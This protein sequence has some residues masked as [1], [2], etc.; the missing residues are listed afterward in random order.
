MSVTG[1]SSEG[2]GGELLH[3]VTSFHL[4]LSRDILEDNVKIALLNARTPGVAATHV[5]LE[6]DRKELFARIDPTLAEQLS[7][8][9][10]QGKVVIST[11]PTRPTYAD[12][13]LYSNT[14]GDAYVAV[15]N[16]DILFP[17]ETVA[18]IVASGLKPAQACFALTRWNVTPNGM[19]IQGMTPSPPWP[20]RHVSDMR[21]HEQNF[22]SY[23]AYVF[24]A[25]IAVPPD[26][27]GVLIGS[28]GCDT[29][30]AAILKASGYV[31]SN[32]A[33]PLR[34]AHFDVKPRSYRSPSAIA[35]LDR[36]VDALVAALRRPEARLAESVR[37]LFGASDKLA[38][39]RLWF[40]HGDVGRFGRALQRAI[41]ATAWSEHASPIPLRLRR[42]KVDRSD[43]ERETFDVDTIVADC[44]AARTFI[45]WEVTGFRQDEHVLDVLMSSPY[46]DRAFPIWQY[47]WQS[48]HAPEHMTRDD[49]RLYDEVMAVFRATLM[50]MREP[51]VHVDPLTHSEAMA[52][53][54]RL[55]DLLRQDLE[56]ETL[57]S[58]R[59]HEASPRILM[60]DP[61]ALG[62]MGHYLPYDLQLQN[63]AAAR[64]IDVSFLMNKKMDLALV[65]SGMKVHLLLD[66][67]SWEIAGRG[68]EHPRSDSFV[69]ALEAAIA[70][71]KRAAPDQVLMIYMY[72]GSFEHARLVQEVMAKYDDVSAVIHLF[73]LSVDAYKSD[74]YL[75][76]W[77]HFAKTV[78]SDPRI[79]LT[80]AT[81]NIQAVLQR[82]TGIFFD[83][84][85]HPSTTFDDKAD[86]SR[87][88][89]KQLEAGQTP[90]VLF[91]G[92]MREEK[93]FLSTVEA[94]RSLT[95][96]G[97][98]KFQCIVAG[99]ARSDTPSALLAGLQSIRN[100]L[101]KIEERGLDE[102]EF[103]DFLASG[104]IVV[105]PYKAAAFAERPSGILIDA[106]TLGRPL[107]VVEGTWLAEVVR[108]YGW[109]EV[110]SDDGG[111]AVA[112]A[113]RKMR[114]RYQQ[115]IDAIRTSREGYI[116]QHSWDRLIKSIVK[117]VRAGPRRQPIGIRIVSY[118]RSDH[119]SV[120]ETGVVARLLRDRKGRRNTLLDVGAHIGTSA[121]FFHEL[122]WTIHCF[123]PD[124]AN[125]EQLVA[126]LGDATS[127]VIDTRAVSDKPA[128]GVAFY[129]SPESTG[130]S[131]L[132]AFRE[133]HQEANVVDVT[134][135]ADYVHAWGI[136]KVDFLK[137]DAEGFDFSVLKGVPWDRIKPDVIECEYEDAKTVPLGHNWEDIAKFLQG[138]GYSV[139]ISEW[140]PIVRYGIA[141]DWR[142]VTPYPGRSIPSE[143]WGNILAFRV[144]P[145]YAA[146]KE[147]FDA[148]LLK[149]AA[150]PKPAVVEIQPLVSSEPALV[151]PDDLR[152][153]KNAYEGKR[154]FVMGNG[155]S[156]NKMDLS[157]LE[158][159]IVFGC[160]SI[161]LLFD[162]VKWRPT[163]YTCVDS[164]VLPDRSVEIA[165]M[166]RD[167]P[168]M[169]A[170]FPTELQD[171][172]SKVLTP[173]R[174]ILPALP[175]VAYFRER[176]NSKD[177]PPF[178]MFSIDINEHVIQPFTVAITMLQ[179]AMYMGFSEIYLIGCDT[180]YTIPPDVKKEGMTERGEI[181]LGLTSTQDNDP[182]H[183]DPRYFGKDRKWHDPQVDKMI[184]H[185][186]YA[187]QVSELRGKTTIF[188]ATVG[189]NL[190]V[191]SRVDFNSLFP[192]K[193]GE[194]TAP[195]PGKVGNGRDSYIR[196]V[197]I[198]VRSPSPLA[199]VAAAVPVPTTTTSAA[200][201]LTLFPIR[202]GPAWGSESFIGR[203]PAAAI[204]PPQVTIQPVL[205]EPVIQPAVAGAE[206]ARM[207]SAAE[208][209][210]GAPATKKVAASSRLPVGRWAVTQILSRRMAPVTLAM[211]AC[212]VAGAGFL[213]AMPPQ[214]D[215]RPM[216][217]AGA[218]VALLG[219]CG[220]YF[221]YRVVKL[222]QRLSAENA[223]LQQRLLETSGA[224]E[225]LKSDTHNEHARQSSSVT[226]IAGRIERSLAASVQD[227]GSRIISLDSAVKD[228]LR[229]MADAQKRAEDSIDALNARIASID[230]GLAGAKA[231]AGAETQR[232]SAL[233][234]HL[235]RVDAASRRTAVSAEAAANDLQASI[236][237]LRLRFEEAERRQQAADAAFADSMAVIEGLT[238]AGVENQV[239]TAGDLELLAE[240]AARIEAELVRVRNKS[241]SD[242]QH[243]SLV[244]ERIAYLDDVSKG[245]ANAAEVASE[246]LGQ[247]VLET[248]NMV[249]AAEQRL[250]SL[251]SL[252]NAGLQGLGQQVLTSEARLTDRVTDIDRAVAAVV[253]S[254]D[255]LGRDFTRKIEAADTRGVARIATLESQV[256][257]IAAKADNDVALLS[258][259]LS[260]L[261]GHAQGLVAEVSRGLADVDNR[262]VDA[263]DRIASLESESL[264]IKRSL[265]VAS[266][267]G[268]E[269]ISALQEKVNTVLSGMTDQ[270]SWV[271]GELEKLSTWMSEFGEKV[272]QDLSN[273]DGRLGTFE[274]SISR[275][276][277][278]VQTADSLV[279]QTASR[280][281]ILSNNL[282]AE[283]KAAL[284]LKADE[285]ESRLIKL[286]LAGLQAAASQVSLEQ[287]LMVTKIEAIR[288]EISAI[289]SKHEVAE[290]AL[291]GELASLAAGAAGWGSKIE[292]LEAQQNSFKHALEGAEAAGDAKLSALLREYAELA[293]AL[294]AVRADAA[295]Q[296]VRFEE[297]VTVVG[298]S[299]V[300]ELAQAESRLRE[301]LATKAD[302]S[303][304]A[305]LTLDVSALKV[306]TDLKADSADVA[307]IK[308]ELAELS[309]LSSEAAV[310]RSRLDA[311]ISASMFDV[312][313]IDTKIEKVVV[314]KLA[315][316]TTEAA[317]LAQTL[318]LI[319]GKQIAL[320]DALDA[321]KA[322]GVREV[323]TIERSINSL[324]KSSATE[325]AQ[326]EARL[327][328]LIVP[329]AEASDVLSIMQEVSALKAWTEQAVV[330]ATQLAEMAQIDAASALVDNASSYR[331]SNR[332]LEVEHMQLLEAQWAPSLSVTTSRQGL[333]YMAARAAEVE[334]EL[335]GRFGAAIE[336]LLVRLLVARATKGAS[337]AI[338]EIGVLFG[339]GAAIVFDAVK[340][341]FSNVHFTLL[342]PLDSS[343]EGR[344]PDALTDH[345]VNE[346]VVRR[347][348]ARAGMG[349]SQFRLLKRSSSDPN[350]LKDAA[351]R[352]YDVLIIDGDRSYQAVKSDFESFSPL[353]RIGGHVVFTGYG[354]DSSPNVRAF[355]DAEV[356]AAETVTSVGVAWD[357]A[358]FRV[359]TVPS[360]P[361]V[362]RATTRNKSSKS[363]KS[364]ASGSKRSRT[365]RKR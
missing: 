222:A 303:D 29:T 183:F 78:A 160:N 62:G 198:P 272:S 348:L 140:H 357:T 275:L 312:A 317:R 227:V 233:A 135:I 137:I 345:P 252:V 98:P 308:S 194:K 63:A 68:I 174:E 5:L 315:E 129:K 362:R 337:I 133:T 37:A 104:D 185:Y 148:C 152:R 347:N 356:L 281:E 240:R 168:T 56:D 278:R 132:H 177:Y 38:R 277:D 273:V 32:P 309:D 122:G 340:D 189:G 131:A 72:C 290:R 248:R 51:G 318:D 107:I 221:A 231:V 43:I 70:S 325:L 320:Q 225:R 108:H 163:F 262:M 276:E 239:R 111:M 363:S 80:V 268:A 18:R 249:E 156:L 141:H 179:I 125:R 207:S 154:C 30:L 305:D 336:D 52:M 326:I 255:A 25:P 67:H 130:I 14:V 296:G 266:V 241:N 54:D 321:A 180:S 284:S 256:S 182:N 195:A 269:Q 264:T 213:L 324:G 212:L 149:R 4:K 53:A 331:V 157:K 46:R 358:V 109:G 158:G 238:E 243:M 66:S 144:D 151:R 171:H 6:G 234:E 247:Q 113:V 304:L 230:A 208:P 102:R 211:V 82:K 20:E 354:S 170:F 192:A 301:L 316:V 118:E 349:P 285:A 42:V 73:W 161:F 19:F 260:D 34:I 2:T 359:V 202:S 84:A 244:L 216:L 162:R 334:R 85:P 267:D 289:D 365:T 178:S 293:L 103:I 206:P 164:R 224:L 235:A 166:L 333:A 86:V 344:V 310:D 136:E 99:R 291:G 292:L 254:V 360:R 253:G 145:G 55:S 343:P 341:R 279:A 95:T 69:A 60:I 200:A 361:T 282:A 307:F 263:F 327:E 23:D 93:G 96:T 342:D 251:T 11:L 21:R 335:D 193:A 204:V 49:F 181:G 79:R 226:S 329:K 59:A 3:V 323:E 17:I 188:N 228:D 112:T 64:S 44:E 12:I 236:V 1:S 203:E 201:G 176:W 299:A 270:R 28:L 246:A 127:V 92:A 351:D 57:T 274:Q 88:P 319:Q 22:F 339:V 355:V 175:N 9:V 350:A 364:N 218:G 110:V 196:P 61:D 245:A 26:T 100:P 58:V 229:R 76:A 167:N 39:G 313:A 288:A 45:E 16:S 83:V 41:G 105:L 153:F 128:S 33:I 74:D 13:F 223:A 50:E 75:N 294:S 8:E 311:K 186:R 24:R 209:S 31:V 265:E 328:A 27:A 114:A 35:D 258:D 155:P 97:E 40:G 306:A 257:T 332:K 300:N 237:N 210:I 77:S 150:P 220:L 116:Q 47:Q 169:Q 120:D 261:A 297:L 322:E 298:A 143:S 117:G 106:I 115:Y 126:R 142:R 242:A 197:Q 184:D 172:I 101:V 7:R 232:L 138:L 159:E 283:H 352:L 295:A 286:E 146:V 81:E 10:E 48:L 173:T 94:V 134:T 121:A 191:F 65:P 330:E 338:L 259:H 287:S 71:E 124:P 280:A 87:W 353:V 214:G 89:L 187:R 15:A 250:S 219:V 271:D 205:H 91:P 215:L 217:F 123:E 36:N 119:I 90:I 139:Y 346:R 199:A 147:A 302:L 190:E 314:A 165:A